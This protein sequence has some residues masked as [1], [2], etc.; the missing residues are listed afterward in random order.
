MPDS[1]TTLELNELPVHALLPP[2]QSRDL[3]ASALFDEFL[4]KNMDLWLED[5]GED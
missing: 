2:L 5:I 1:T 3:T 4:A